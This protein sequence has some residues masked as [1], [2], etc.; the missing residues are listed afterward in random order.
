MVLSRAGAGR[1]WQ[2]NGGERIV[3]TRGWLELQW[4]ANCVGE[5]RCDEE[6]KI[7]QV[8]CSRIKRLALWPAFCALG[9]WVD[10]SLSRRT[11]AMHF[12]A[13]VLY[14]VMLAVEE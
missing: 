11:Q 10:P 5:E 14:I 8:C 4:G 3:Q 1:R 9:L 13:P 6:S 7:V 2:E 12:L